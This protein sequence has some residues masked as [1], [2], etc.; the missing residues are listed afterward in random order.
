V[1]FAL[2]LAALIASALVSVP[3]T[4]RARGIVRPATGV[5]VVQAPHEGHVAAVNVAMGAAV[6]PGDSVAVV[7]GR[8]VQAPVAGTV[9]MV[10]VQRGE[11]L[12]AGTPLVKIV[13]QGDMLVGFMMV[14]SSDRVHLK[15]GQS[16]Q[17]DFDAYPMAE[18]GPG[19]GRVRTIGADPITPGLAG[20]YLAGLELPAEPTFLVEVQIDSLPSRARGAPTNGMTFSGVVRV[21]ERRLISLVFSPLERLLG[22]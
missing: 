1:L 18:M 6:V 21:R 11:Y 22:G 2:V 13:P 16:V 10:A 15:P 14:A 7:D 8:A 4:A 9:D 19:R 5:T 3:I 20:R 17:I 12:A